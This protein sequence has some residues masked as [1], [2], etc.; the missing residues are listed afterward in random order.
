[1]SGAYPQGRAHS[2]AHCEPELSVPRLRGAVAGTVSGRLHEGPVTQGTWKEDKKL[3][4]SLTVTVKGASYTLELSGKRPKKGGKSDLAGD[5]KVG[6][7]PE[8]SAKCSF[9]AKHEDYTVRVCCP[10][11]PACSQV[12]SP[13]PSRCGAS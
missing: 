4:L 3:E 7:E 10:T 5:A 1:M 12:L 9:S 13:R 8:P 11:A 6:D 2:D